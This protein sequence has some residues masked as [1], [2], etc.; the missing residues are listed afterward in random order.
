[1]NVLLCVEFLG[2][3]FLELIPLLFCYIEQKFWY[4][5][6]SV[7]FFPI[8]ELLIIESS[9]FF[10]RILLSKVEYSCNRISNFYLSY[11]KFKIHKKIGLGMVNNINKSI[12]ALTLETFQNTKLFVF[13]DE[14]LIFQNSMNSPNLDDSRENNYYSFKLTI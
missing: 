12:K 5:V 7:F 3:I 2:T 11:S 1:M 4:I 10:R 13:N 6:S 14:I 8:K 9:Y